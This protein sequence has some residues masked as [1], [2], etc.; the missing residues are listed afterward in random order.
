MSAR[1]DPIDVHCDACGAR[2][3][4]ECRTPSGEVAKSTHIDR[5]ANASVIRRHMDYLSKRN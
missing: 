4:T 1:V 3:G 2:P 5:R